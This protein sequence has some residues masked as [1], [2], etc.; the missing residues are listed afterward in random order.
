MRQSTHLHDRRDVPS[1]PK[2]AL[3]KQRNELAAQPSIDDCAAAKKVM[4]TPVAKHEQPVTLA[5]LTLDSADR[6]AHFLLRC[7]CERARMCMHTVA[8][9]AT[10]LDIDVTCGAIKAVSYAASVGD[11]A[12]MPYV[13]AGAEIIESVIEV[14]CCSTDET[15]PSVLRVSVPLTWAEACP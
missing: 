12:G 1:K 9:C 8:C 11:A 4:K 7:R 6:R 14:F 13:G 10:T 3:M 5:A 15:L 2:S